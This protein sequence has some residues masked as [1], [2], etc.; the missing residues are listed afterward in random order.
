MRT[1]FF[2]FLIIFISCDSGKKK[3]INREYPWYLITKKA[4]PNTPSKHSPIYGYTSG[5]VNQF[6]DTIIP[7]DKY[8][9]CYTDTVTDFA[10]VSVS[11]KVSE[12]GLTGID[13][14]E[15]K[16]FNA[17]WSLEPVPIKIS[18]G[19][20][21]IVENSKYGFANKKGKIIIK[22]KY[23][24]AKSFFNGKAKVSND[25]ELIKSEHHFWNMKKWFY[26][27]KEGRRVEHN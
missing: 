24:C 6:G 11:R 18:D 7:L 13:K 4:H 8:A 9:R 2:L 22:P 25:C 12:A 26:I 27:D 16:L 10:I 14:N 3:N 23:K 5:Y 15:K 1:L 17:V 20:I 19:M 21:L